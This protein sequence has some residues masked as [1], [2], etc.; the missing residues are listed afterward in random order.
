MSR[1][2]FGLRGLFCQAIG[3]VAF[4]TVLTLGYLAP[5]NAQSSTTAWSN[6][7]FNVDVPNV[8]R[9]SNIVLQT[10]N[11]MPSSSMPLGNGALGAAVWT[12]GGFTAQ[13]NRDDTFP[14]RKSPGQVTIPGLSALTGAAN[15]SAYLDLYN[16]ALIETGGGMT[17]TI[18]VRAT[19]DELVVDVTGANPSV[20]QTVQAYLWSPRAPA[21][22][23][24]GKIATLAETFQD[25][26]LG[27]TGTTFG[28]LLAITAG[29]RNITSSVVGPRT[30]QLQFT[31]NANGSFRV[32]IGAPTWTGGN[33]ISTATSLFGSDAT[34]ASAT[35]EASHITWWNNYWASANLL[36]ASS[37]DGSA[38][39]L[40]NLR[41]IYLYH[42]ASLNRGVYPGNHA[43]VADLFNYSEDDHQWNAWDYW[44]WNMRMH[45]SANLGSGVESLNTAYFNLY[46]NN[47]A[48]IAAWTSANVTNSTGDCV[49][50][51]MR[52]NGNG[53]YSTG[54]PDDGASCTTLVT[55]SYNSLTFSSGTEISL[56]VWRQYQ[57]TKD[58]AFLQTGYPL[59]KAAAQFLLSQATLG[60]DGFLHTTANAHETQWDVPDPVTDIVAMS[61]LFPA[62]VSAAQVLNT[63]QTFVSQLKS[64]EA[65]I[66]PLPR[67]DA[68]THQQVLTASAD[69]AGNDVVA[70]SRQPYATLENTGENLDLEALWPYN[71]VSD[72]SPMLALF[73]RTYAN[74]LW[75][76]VGDFDDS[77]IEAA[78]LGMPSQVQTVLVQNV[79]D[80][81]VYPTGFAL[82][83]GWEGDREPVSYDEQTGIVTTALN[84]AMVQDYDGILRVAP[85]WPT[86]WTASGTVSI[87]NNGKVDVQ[88]ENGA[89]VTVVLEAGATAS[90]TVRSPWPGKSVEVIDAMSSA[91]VVSPT[92]AATFSIAMTSG[93]KYLIEQ[94]SAPFTSLSYARVT[95]TPA[96]A[97]KLLTGAVTHGVNGP[98][99]PP[100]THTVQI[101][102]P[103]ASLAGAFNNV[104][105]TADSNTNPGNF[106]G[107]GLS[108]SASALAAAGVTAGGIKTV[109]GVTFT[110][111]ST[112]GSG[113]PD[114][115]VA[116]G[117]LISL[118]G[119]GKTLGFLVSSSY[120][121]VSGTGTITYTDGSTQSFTLSAPDWWG[122]SSGTVAVSPA[123]LNVRGN[124]TISQTVYV[125]FV[126]VSLNSVKT[127][128]SIRLPK[129]SAAAIYGAPALHIFAMS[130]QY[131]NLSS[132]YNNVGITAD[133]STS[134]GNFDGGGLSFSETALENVGAQPSNSV[135][136][137]G[138]S[139]TWPPSAGT[140]A[141]DNVVA[142]GQV[143]AVNKA[144]S[145]LGFLLASSYGPATST[146]T[147]TYTDGTTQ[148]FTLTAPDWWG[149]ASAGSVAFAPTYLNSPG[150]TSSNQAVDVYYVGVA[151]TKTKTVAT[152]QLP[153]VSAVPTA[154]TA[155]F[156]IFSMGIH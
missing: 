67:T 78:R 154:G 30:V 118:S 31:P 95:G 63:D 123:Y 153:N 65:Q 135:T 12:A 116:N 20:T 147:I 80:Y 127:L 25:N 74:R 16:G 84:E 97:P 93:H 156:H 69:A 36:E 73:N 22:A 11:V 52:Y 14:D 128:A 79:L 148:S 104:G 151:L 90:Q 38:Q 85:G 40:E 105:V 47:V 83:N 87:Q 144:G 108:F 66:P 98:L 89:P 48:N 113:A 138:V 21:A 49:P 33:A 27:G 35:L 8:V 115:V 53:H 134:A 136:F 143:I 82:L 107:G 145:T 43:G 39:Y 4:T 71:M 6:G 122:P 34:V 99:S 50:E 57:Q 137:G 44:F 150:N 32:V 58:L 68:A 121:P 37:T 126:G 42:E 7:A 102:L 18:Y 117:Q 111:P 77:A 15:F 152:V 131:A 86:S 119:S 41:T 9:R 149:G 28:T 59:M 125:N 120:G 142:A 132:A 62:V 61:T 81:Q 26:Y 2:A 129:V 10:P 101:G 19:S 133:S 109:G 56:W 94:T 76:N 110:W 91:T 130:L 51:T 112:A 24:S 70:Y 55:P 146:G 23:A 17:A 96:S 140:G 3:V 1:D 45:I 88:Y 155:A 64:A 114:N 60:S 54:A 5:A 92:T 100:V 13:L 72:T 75:V 141:P 103:Y 29:G 106:D 139:F 46:T 124:T